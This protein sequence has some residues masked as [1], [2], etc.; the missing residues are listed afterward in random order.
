MPE[1]VAN[2]LIQ[3]GRI[4]LDPAPNGDLVHCQP[5]LRH[6]FLQIPVAER[7]PQIPTDTQNNNHVREVSPTEQRR[8]VLGHRITLPDR[9]TRVCN[10]SREAAFWWRVWHFRTFCVTAM[11]RQAAAEMDA[12]ASRH[13]TFAGS[14]VDCP[15]HLRV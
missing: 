1:L 10:R 8:P 7:V 9:S 13:A 4:A 3:N 6:D 14:L 11:T 2:P 12:H 15:R 5:A